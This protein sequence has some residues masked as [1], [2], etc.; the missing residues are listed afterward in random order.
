MAALTLADLRKRYGRIETFVGMMKHKVPF[1][2]MNGDEKVIS[3]IGFTDRSG[4]ITE[5]SP[6]K[7]TRQHTASIEWLKTRASS[8][9]TIILMTDKERFALKELSRTIEFG[10]GG[11]GN[12]SD[13]VEAIFAISVF[14]KFTSKNTI[15]DEADVYKVI[16][17]LDPIREKQ[18]ITAVSPNLE[19]GISDVSILN[20]NLPQGVLFSLVDRITQASLKPMVQNGVNYANS[21]TVMTWAKTLYEN[22]RYNKIE[23]LANGK[24]KQ[25]ESKV[26]VYVAIDDKPVDVSLSLKDSDIKQYGKVQGG[27]FDDQRYFWNSMIGINPSSYE[28]DYYSALK[29]GGT[30]MDAIQKVYLG[31]AYEIN[32]RLKSNQNKLLSDLSSGVLAFSTLNKPIASINPMLTKQE[33]NVFEYDNLSTLLSTTSVK[34]TTT[35][36]ATPTIMFLD[37][38]GKVL[39]TIRCV[40]LNDKIKNVIEKGSLLIELSGFVVA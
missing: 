34:V 28:K 1:V 2:M 38:R 17:G 9:S 24:L 10:G 30:Y 14:C 18:I 15:I 27:G 12:Y 39:L 3:R 33:K 7:D 21:Q 11:K 22:N 13:L 29:A 20:L 5:F 25:S 6:S 40:Q 4:R 35:N 26:E 36:K 8:G 23:V 16:S 31:I 32:N 19:K 37:N